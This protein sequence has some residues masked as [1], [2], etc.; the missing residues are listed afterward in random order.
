MVEIEQNQLMISPQAMNVD[1]PPDKM[2]KRKG[3]WGGP[4]NK[5]PTVITVVQ[6]CIDLEKVNLLSPCPH[7][8][9][10][11]WSP[12]QDTLLSAPPGISADPSPKNTVLMD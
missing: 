11:S 10:W 6:L 7:P 5:T 8:Q 9:P 12:W 2:P 3:C 1:T 4:T